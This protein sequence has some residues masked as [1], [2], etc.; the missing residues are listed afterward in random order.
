MGR[1]F[2]VPFRNVLGDAIADADTTIAAVIAADTAGHRCRIREIALG[3]SDNAPADLNMGVSLQRTGNTTAG[4]AASSPTPEPLDSDSLASIISAG[5]DYTAEP[6]TYGTALWAIELHRQ[7]SLIK[8]WAADDP[9][10]PVCNQNE[11]IG[12]I[13]TPRTAA[14]ATMSGHI[15][16]EEF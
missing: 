14:A 3:F 12:L 2:A 16:F 10:A 4:T 8:E 7:N 15:V 11:T 5:V 9:A 1:C 13:T 6:T